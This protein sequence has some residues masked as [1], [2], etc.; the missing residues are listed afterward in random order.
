V[1]WN[2]G[3]GS[4]AVTGTLTPT[5]T[6]SQKGI[7]TVTL[8]ITDD[9]GGTTSDTLTVAVDEESACKITFN[10]VDQNGELGGTGDEKVYIDGHGW[11]GNGEQVAVEPD[12]KIFYRA[13]YKEG[14]GL[15]GPRFSHV[16]TA[17]TT[18]NLV[19][20]TLTIDFEDQNGPLAGTGE[21][22]VYIDHIG[23][24]SNNG[25]LT[26]PLDSTVLHRAYFK[27]GSGLKGP[28]RREKINDSA[29]DLK[30]KFHR[31]T[32]KFEDQNG[33][34]AGTGHER[35]YIDHVGY[36]TNSNTVTVPLDSTVL[37]RAYFKKG[38][39]L[40]GPKRRET[41]DGSTADLIV[42]FH[43]LTMQFEDQ[44]GDLIGTG[45]ERV[46]LDHVGYKANGD[47]ITVPLDSTVLHRAYYKEGS[48][49]KGPKLKQNIEGAD[50]NL[51]VKFW[52]VSF[53]VFHQ[54]TTNPVIGAQTYVDHV[55]YVDNG[56][57]IIVPADST[58]RHRAKVG[59]KWSGKTSRAIDGSWT[60]CTYEW[61]GATFNEPFYN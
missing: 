26:V 32:M 10:F 18:L 1:E 43:K 6:Y 58:I 41:I 2:F 34:L 38:S 39:V 25:K 40:K 8:T 59:S 28:K 55:G 60:G 61:N 52:K 14:S 16:C 53:E 29:V 44:K 4:P 27:E 45:N 35:V 42:K 17:D 11:K 21:E 13:Y 56:G 22:R 51:T 15:K 24:K 23:Y 9:D 57:E 3:D 12:T 33:D 50:N 7:Y 48:G 36:L 31:L 49:L 47:T 37:H 19:Y 20:R 46:N 54:S 30:V 5:H